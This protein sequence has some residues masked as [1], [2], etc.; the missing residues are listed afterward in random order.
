MSRYQSVMCSI[1]RLSRLSRDELAALFPKEDDRARL[2]LAL[3]RLLRLKEST[4]ECFMPLY[5]DEHR[6]LVLMG[7]AGSGKSI[8][9][10]RKILERVLSEGGHRYLVIRKVGKTLRNSCFEQLV[11]QLSSDYP[12]AEWK[13]NR[14]DMTISFANG[15]KIIMSGI[16][17]P[18]KI[19]SIYGI[20]GI[21][22]EEASELEQQ[23]LEQLNLRLRDKSAYYKQIIITFNPISALHWLKKRFFDR[24]DPEVLTHRS[25]YRD[26]RF[27]PD[28][29]RDRLESYKEIDPYYYTVYCLG[30][31][32][33]AGRSVF[34][35]QAVSERL[36]SLGTPAKQGCF[37]F[38]YDGVR[39]SDIR[40][41]AEDNGSLKIYKDAESGVPYVIGA[42]TAGEGSDYNVA[43]VLDNRDGSQVATLRMQGDEDVFARQLYCLGRHYN[44]A[45]IS[46]ETNLSTYP[47]RELERLKYPKQYAREVMDDYTH[48]SRRSFGF[49]TDAKSR[50]VLI[51]NLI[52]FAREHL[53]YIRDRD[54]LEEMLTF[55]RN[56]NLRPEAEN[57]AHDDCVMSLG[58]AHMARDQQS[59]AE[60]L[61]EKTVEWTEDMWEDYR[62]ADREGKE[63]LIGKWGKPKR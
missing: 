32:G 47:V 16:D 48:S 40:F 34:D 56:E 44:N 4:N 26:N 30:E 24:D 41:C 19:K 63:Y 54:T 7:G 42:D 37:E 58:I 57:G 11:G 1:E 52:A 38:S 39:I 29:Y 18:E 22:I 13:V 5:F 3:A 53:T 36:S 9:A 21:W 43:Q 27:L 35:A 14:T 50:P 49:R 51:S 8:F 45:L 23:D 17:D 61:T 12:G 25:N 2:S 46:V 59:Y 62:R 28:D 20:T 10:G 15:S 31:W 6:F 33:T 60:P 55:I